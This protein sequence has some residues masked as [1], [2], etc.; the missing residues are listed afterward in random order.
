MTRGTT[1]L[2]VVPAIKAVL[3]AGYGDAA[4]RAVRAPLEPVT[5]EAEIAACAKVA[6]LFA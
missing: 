2:P 3:A 4:W 1:G 6:A 5:D